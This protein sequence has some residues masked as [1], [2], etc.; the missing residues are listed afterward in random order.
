MVLSN[1]ERNLAQTQDVYVEVATEKDALASI[2]A[3][4]VW[5]YCVRLNVVRGHPSA[6]MLEKMSRSFYAARDQGQRCVLLYMG[7][8]DPTGLQIPLAIEAN[9]LER[10]DIEIELIRIAL[11]PDQVDAYNL[12]IDTDPD[13]AKKGDPNYARWVEYCDE[14]YPVAAPVELDALHPS[15]LEAIVKHELENL[16]D[17]DEFAKQQRIEARE[18]KTLKKMRGEMLDFAAAKWPKLF[19]VK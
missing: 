8:L 2:I 1:Y 19:G 12:P 18:R 9:L 15:V 13:A 10:H 6:T 3:E 7:D 17:M 5:P 4:L 16:L 14:Q 11:N